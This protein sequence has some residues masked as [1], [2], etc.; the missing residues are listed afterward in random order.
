M[1]GKS[2]GNAYPEYGSTIS[3]PR[4]FGVSPTSSLVLDTTT[5]PSA[6]ID[7]WQAAV[8]AALARVAHLDAATRQLNKASEQ[9]GRS[10]ALPVEPTEQARIP[11]WTSRREWLRQFR[12]HIN[13][14]A[15][16]ALCARRLIKPDK[17]YAV[18]EAHADFAE[19]RTGR[20]VTAARS[21]IAARAKVSESAVNRTRRILIDLGMGFEHARGRNLKTIEF[22]AAE[23]HHG[24]QQHRAASTWALSSPQAIVVSTPPIKTPKYHSSRAG[25]RA[26][27]YRTRQ[28]RRSDTV[29]EFQQPNQVPSATT[30]ADTLSSVSFLSCEVLPLGRT[31][32]R[33][34][35][36][37]HQDK[38]LNCRSKSPRPIEVQRTAAELIT[39]APALSPPGHIGAVCDVLIHAGIDHTRWTGRDIARALSF[40]TKERG[41]IWPTASSLTSPLGYLKHRIKGIDWTKKS[42]SEQRR[43]ADLARR[44]EQEQLERMHEQRARAAANPQHRAHVLAG[45]RAHLSAKLQPG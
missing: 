4:A 32:Q 31:H 17:A 34:S 30:A 13:S 2:Q 16:R 27:K 7:E 44:K 28:S 1:A 20:G 29:T 6:N 25:K 9:R 33:A 37:T 22:L 36:R 18:A 40:D 12:H 42:P 3:Q 8:D 21:T 35:A 19:S 41:W 11:V 39:H 38:N 43:A 24:G 5:S 14:P 23:A 10:W 26:A 45:I 15:G